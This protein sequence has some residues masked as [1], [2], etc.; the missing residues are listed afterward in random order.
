V[1]T[2]K[3]GQ[4]R[5]VIEFAVTAA[6]F[7]LS[8]GA[9]QR[10][11]RLAD[12]T[13]N[14]VHFLPFIPFCLIAVAVVRFHRSMDEMQRIRA[15]QINSIAMLLS[16]LSFAGYVFVEPF[17]VPRFN[18]LTAFIILWLS[19]AIAGVFIKVRD[20]GWARM[21]LHAAPMAVAFG[22]LGGVYYA[23]HPAPERMLTL[24]VVTV[25]GAAVLQR[26]L[27]PPA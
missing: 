14:A 6:L 17:G 9:V 5:Y 25:I 22:I 18:L 4:R 7:I 21:L 2:V 24:A 13:W 19:A 1:I 27:W 12:P 26:Y 16:V 11:G 3:H 15:G 23:M 8:V 20:N 10:V